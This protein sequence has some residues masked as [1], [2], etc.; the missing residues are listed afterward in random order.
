MFNRPAMHSS[1]DLPGGFGAS[2]AED[3]QE[4]A[5]VEV[6]G[7]DGFAAIAAVHDVVNGARVLNAKLAGHASHRGHPR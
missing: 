6:V 7:E 2:F 3:F 4:A 1:M 5:P